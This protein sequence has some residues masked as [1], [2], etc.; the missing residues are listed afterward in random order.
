MPLD[1]VFHHD[2]IPLLVKS[3]YGEEGLQLWVGVLQ[4]VETTVAVIA[5]KKKIYLGYR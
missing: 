2:R 5:G 3:S 4:G 1:G